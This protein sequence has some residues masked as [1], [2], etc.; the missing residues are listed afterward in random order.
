MFRKLRCHI[1]SHTTV[2]AYLSLFL[3]MGGG[4]A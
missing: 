3:V 1:P 2:A 4:A